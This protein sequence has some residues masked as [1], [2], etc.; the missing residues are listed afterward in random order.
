MILVEDLLTAILLGVVVLICIYF[1]IML[2][3]VMRLLA[4]TNAKRIGTSYNMSPKYTV[5]TN[6]RNNKRKKKK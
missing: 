3:K 5:K 6:P 1:F 2:R 4:S